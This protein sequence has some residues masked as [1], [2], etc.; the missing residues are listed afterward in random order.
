MFASLQK[1]I[2]GV[3]KLE[4]SDLFS[5]ALEAVPFYIFYAL[6]CFCLLRQNNF[7]SRFLNG[8]KKICIDNDSSQCFLTYQRRDEFEKDFPY[9]GVE[10][11]KKNKKL[12][13]KKLFYKN[14][15]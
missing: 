9:E 12:Q 4:S 1:N 5:W 14:N 13:N 2:L 10:F 7:Y 3:L 6:L 15:R 11:Y 8:L